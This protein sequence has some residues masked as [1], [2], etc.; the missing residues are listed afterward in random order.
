MLVLSRKIGESVVIAGNIRVTVVA[1]LGN[2]IR[3]GI[4]A[5]EE[6]PIHRQEIYDR[7]EGSATEV[8]D[9]SVLPG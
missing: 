7:L 9:Q 4:T 8:E 1:V 3:L 6:V 5:P 2:K